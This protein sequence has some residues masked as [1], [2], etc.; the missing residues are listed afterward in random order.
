MNYQKKHK[1]NNLLPIRKFNNPN[2]NTNKKSNK[3]IKK[4]PFLKKKTR[5]FN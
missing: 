3:R 5:V 1:E 2:T 4:Y